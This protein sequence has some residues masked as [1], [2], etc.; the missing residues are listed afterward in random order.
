MQNIPKASSISCLEILRGCC[1]TRTSCGIVV[2]LSEM[3]SV[4][5]GVT[6]NTHFPSIAHT[7]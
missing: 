5:P 7:L 6:E 3:F 2:T 1:K 4:C